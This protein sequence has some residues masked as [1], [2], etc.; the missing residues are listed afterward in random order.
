MRVQQLQRENSE[1]S[2]KA[3]VQFQVHVEK[4]GGRKHLRIGRLFQG[5]GRVLWHVD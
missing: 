4:R 3:L 5:T 1:L 2:R